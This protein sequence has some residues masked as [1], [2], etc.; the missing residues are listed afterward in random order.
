VGAALRAAVL[1]FGAGAVAFRAV[2]LRATVPFFA[3]LLLAEAAGAD[4]APALVALRAG[5]LSEAERF[6]RGFGREALPA[7]VRFFAED[8]E[9]L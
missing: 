1:D 6:T 9:E 7:N 4:L 2:V 5:A 3:V 8:V